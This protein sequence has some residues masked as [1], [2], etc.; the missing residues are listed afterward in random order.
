MR[1]SP[2][3]P[4]VQMATISKFTH[5]EETHENGTAPVPGRRRGADAGGNFSERAA[6]RSRPAATTA[7]VRTPDHPRA[8]EEG[9]GGRRGRGEE[10]Q[11]ERRHQHPG[12]GRQ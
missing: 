6:T 5:K 11:V 12:L 4:A 3:T 9:H 2:T 7:A 8:G 10:E 1:P